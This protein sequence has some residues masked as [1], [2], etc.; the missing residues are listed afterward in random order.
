[1]NIRIYRESVCMGEDTEDHSMIYT[2]SPADRF[3]DIFR[4]LIAQKYFPVTSQDNA[5]WTLFCSKDDL[6]TWKPKEDKLYSRFV[7][8]E[9]AILSVKRWLNPVIKFRYYPS[10]IDRAQ[11]IF[12]MFNGLKFHIWH[13]GFW[14]EYESYSIPQE[15]EDRWRAML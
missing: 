15:V 6:V 3:T 11:Y 2:L 13:E 8:E 7:T 4:D 9:P 14:P 10:P 1:M 5:V 12:T